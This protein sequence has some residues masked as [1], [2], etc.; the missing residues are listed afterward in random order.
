M[1]KY[2]Q[3]LTSI[4]IFLFYFDMFFAK[5]V[6]KLYFMLFYKIGGYTNVEFSKVCDKLNMKSESYYIENSYN[7]IL[8]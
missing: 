5:R 7:R 3:I 2:L 4:L 1:A 8:L 6:R